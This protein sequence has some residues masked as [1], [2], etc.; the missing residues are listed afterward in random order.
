MERELKKANP[1]YNTDRWEH[2]RQSILRRD[3]FMCQ[4]AKRYGRRVPAEL[5]HH[6]LPREY[7]P[8]YQWEPWNLISLSNKAHEEMHYRT[9]RDLTKKGLEWA[10]RTARKQNIDLDVIEARL[11]KPERETKRILVIGLRGT[12]KTTYCRENIGDDC[13]VYDLDAIASSFRLRREHEEVFDPARNIANDYLFDF[14]RKS[15]EYK[16]K[17][18][19][20]I[21]AAPQIEELEKIMPDQVVHCSTKYIDRPMKN[22]L[23]AIRRIERILKWCE[24]K[25]VKVLRPAQKEIPPGS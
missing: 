7:F 19:F 16:I 13:L 8:E 6:I 14:I 17:K 2:L 23:D 9:T 1:Y 15:E 5:V 25:E 21:R 22:Q 12:G 3:K 4:D 24:E 20:I 10:I 18:I 11:K